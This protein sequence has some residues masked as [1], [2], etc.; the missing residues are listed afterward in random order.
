MHTL[1]LALF[2]LFSNTVSM[3][4]LQTTSIT[5]SES[6]GQFD[7]DQND[8]DVVIMENRSKSVKKDGLSY[9]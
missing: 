5:I 7:I 8:N 9:R 4:M 1:Y 6:A 2:L 3:T